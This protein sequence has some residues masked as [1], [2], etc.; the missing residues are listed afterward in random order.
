[1]RA[2]DGLQVFAP[3]PNGHARRTLHPSRVISNSQRST[4]FGGD[5]PDTELTDMTFSDP[6]PVDEIV[7][8]RLLVGSQE[9]PLVGDAVTVGRGPNC[10]IRLASPKVSTL[11][12]H[13][14]R[15][16]GGWV[17][18]D[19]GSQNRI[20]DERR[21]AVAKL[22]LRPGLPWYVAKT[23]LESFTAATQHA[24]KQLRPLLGFGGASPQLIDA[25]IAAAAAGRVLV[26][27][28]PPGGAATRVADLLHK[29]TPRRRG[30]LVAGDVRDIVGG[31]SDGTRAVITKRPVTRTVLGQLPKDAYVVDIRPLSE[32]REDIPALLDHLVALGRVARQRPH[33]EIDGAARERAT[34]D[35][36][37]R[38]FEELEQFVERE[39][40]LQDNDQA[41][42]RTA[43]EL[44]VARSTLSKWRR[45]RSG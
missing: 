20:L 25:A 29:A 38:N 32:R 31:P 10:H 30:E 13:I 18:V 17:A 27:A 26:I 43:A 33:L 42:N 6:D 23:P 36:W 7:G 14:V 44:G 39:L 37:R 22:R 11:H 28:E 21:R 9:W 19:N 2:G 1:M 5:V 41:N 40:A 4:L 34:T 12:C 16:D 3:E 24:R 45:L 35:R 15:L 8:V